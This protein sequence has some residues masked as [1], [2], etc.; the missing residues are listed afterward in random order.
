MVDYILTGD[1]QDADFGGHCVFRV[2]NMVEID[3][4]SVGS[5]VYRV[6]AW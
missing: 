6:T 3:L 1:I 4:S 5:C 2:V